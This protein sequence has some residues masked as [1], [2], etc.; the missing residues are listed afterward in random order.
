MNAT[1]ASKQSN[2]RSKSG[3][4]A[5][6]A[7]NGSVKMGLKFPENFARNVAFVMIGLAVIA[8]YFLTPLPAAIG[9][10]VLAIARLGIVFW[11]IKRGAIGKDV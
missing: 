9:I 6:T 2:M 10:T 1:Q 8:S 3:N 4:R 7:K 5:K 11:Q